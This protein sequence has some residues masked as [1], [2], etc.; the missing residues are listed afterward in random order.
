[1]ALFPSCSYIRK[2]KNVHFKYF[3]YIQ[4]RMKK[5]NHVRRLQLK[6]VL[7]L[8]LLQEEEEEEDY[9]EITYRWSHSCVKE[10]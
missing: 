3:V 9:R 4:N 8:L 2:Y 1:M 7:L 5:V 6:I 10:Q